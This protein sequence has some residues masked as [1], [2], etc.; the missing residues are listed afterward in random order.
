[1]NITIV[2]VGLIG[3]SIAM[4]LKG[5]QTKIIGVDINKQHA[6]EAVKLGLVDAILPLE[7]AVKISDLVVVCIPV[8]AS[9]KILPLILD[10]VGYSTVVVDMGSTKVSVCNAIRNHP[11]RK[12][13]VASHPIAGT[14]NSG[15]SAAIPTLFD[16]KVSIICEQELSSASALDLITHLY[17]LLKMRI[18]YMDPE[19]HDR[20]IA[21]VSH[22][23]H[24][25]SFAL[26]LTVLEIEKNEENIFNM[27]GS[28]FASTARLAKSSPEMWAPI[29]HQN[30]ENI[31]MALEAYIT[32]LKRFKDMIDSRDSLGTFNLMKEANDIRRILE[33]IK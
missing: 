11:N 10:N 22:L 2:G 8:D 3:G 31:S 15:P 4:K 1:M 14:E 5:F 30:A 17:C 7:E 21:F 20:H 27:A 12:N 33:G 6:D 29:F 13:L 28:G 32:N 16:N 25:T 26:G 9:C 19:S 18:I 23:S 24:I